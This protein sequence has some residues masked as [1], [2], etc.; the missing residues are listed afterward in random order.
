MQAFLCVM[1][2]KITYAQHL[3]TIDWC[4][5]A[6][7]KLNND[8]IRMLLLLLILLQWIYQI[9]RKANEGTYNSLSCGV[10]QAHLRTGMD[11]LVQFHGLNLFI[12]CPAGSSSLNLKLDKQTFLQQA[13]TGSIALLSRQFN[14]MNKLR[15]TMSWDQAHERGA[16]HCYPDS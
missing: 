9:L 8:H 1:M 15:K 10:A 4:K 11:V 7:P 5:I 13:W 3:G 12:R 2:I 16:L 6:R 14:M